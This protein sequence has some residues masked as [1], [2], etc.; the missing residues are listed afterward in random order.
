[1]PARIGLDWP[2]FG[3]QLGAPV[4]LLGRQLEQ[5]ARLG[6]RA[7]PVVLEHGRMAAFVSFLSLTAPEVIGS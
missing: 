2:S 6:E 5:R 4:F 1:L 7:P 3:V